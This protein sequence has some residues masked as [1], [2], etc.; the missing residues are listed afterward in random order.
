MHITAAD[1][2]PHTWSA[3]VHEVC[4]CVV[5]DPA[6]SRLHTT[7][8]RCDSTWP[9]SLIIIALTAHCGLFSSEEI[10]RPAAQVVSYQYDPAARGST[11]CTCGHEVIGT[12]GF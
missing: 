5:T 10:S 9:T 3:A 4:Q 1:A 11:S 8:L 2:V 6:E 12:P 7:R